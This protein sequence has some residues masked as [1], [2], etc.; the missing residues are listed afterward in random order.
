MEAYLPDWN[1]REKKRPQT[2]DNFLTMWKVIL[3]HFMYQDHSLGHFQRKIDMFNLF[4]A[5]WAFL[6]IFGQKPTYSTI[7]VKIGIIDHF[8]STSLFST[9]FGQKTTF[10]TTS[11]QNRHFRPFSFK[12]NIFDHFQPKFDIFDH[13]RSKST[14]P[15]IFGQN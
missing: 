9:S 1:E 4:Q 8:R 15:T 2:S 11:D 3:C 14:F 6:T 5:K 12:N 7:L 13:F 10:S